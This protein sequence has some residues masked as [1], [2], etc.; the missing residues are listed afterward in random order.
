MATASLLDQ[1]HQEFL[2]IIHNLRTSNDNLACEIAHL[3]HQNETFKCDKVREYNATRI[4]VERLQA[5]L[6][7]K[8]NTIRTLN[9]DLAAAVAS[10]ERLWEEATNAIKARDAQL[11]E[12][13]MESE[14]RLKR[15][16]TAEAERD[17][18]KVEVDAAKKEV[19]EALDA[20]LQQYLT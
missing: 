5:E 17:A 20:K 10:R 3:R 14:E 7:A 6:G 1:L 4:G 12:L 2:H 15:V 8:D 11:Q 16:T 13:R 19:A 18:Y 9:G